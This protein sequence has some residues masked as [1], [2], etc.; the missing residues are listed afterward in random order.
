[1]TFKHNEHLFEIIER[2]KAGEE[3]AFSELYALT[4]GYVYQKARQIT[5]DDNDTN[6]LVQDVYIA[7]YRDIHKLNRNESLYGWLKTVTFRQG[8][9]LAEKKRKSGYL[10]EDEA[11]VFDMI[12]D[13]AA[14]IEESFARQ[15]DFHFIK[16]C[17]QELSEEQRQ[18]AIAYYYDEMKIDEIA[19]RLGISPGTVKSRL[20]VARKKLKD[21]LLEEEQ[22]QGYRFYSF[23]TVWTGIM[24]KLAEL[25]A[26]KIAVS[27]ISVG[28]AAATAVTGYVV[29]K[30][31][32]TPPPEEKPVVQE[33]VVDEPETEEKEQVERPVEE[34]ETE[35]APN[36]EEEVKLEDPREVDSSYESDTKGPSGGQSGVLPYGESTTPQSFTLPE[37]RQVSVL[38]KGT[39][40][41][42]NGT[43][44]PI[45]GRFLVEFIDGNGTVVASS[46]GELY[47]EDT[48]VTE[49]LAAGTYTYVLHN[50][51]TEMDLFDELPYDMWIY[52]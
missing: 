34:E 29:V 18:V 41:N 10:A 32:Q 24:A 35:P 42:S 43:E 49:T 16:E 11:A 7:L 23:G 2:V 13:E 46:T 12:V 39:W 26:K 28:L 44:D 50:E 1:M 9:K 20:H 21:I 27:T 4:Y 37:S 51:A 15:Q 8:I 31:K 36:P 25:G 33:V 52:Y 38:L 47:G 5:N 19:K 40:L 3:G 22:K 6:D 30:E 14:E 45:E 48:V 17:L